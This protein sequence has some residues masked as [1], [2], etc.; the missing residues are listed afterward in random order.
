MEFVAA[1]QSCRHA[2]MWGEDCGFGSSSIMQVQGLPQ[3]GKKNFGQSPRDKGFIRDVPS[4]R[5]VGERKH[6][7]KILVQ[8]CM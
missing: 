1:S 3:V 6:T 7:Y 8:W 5:R 4:L 2:K